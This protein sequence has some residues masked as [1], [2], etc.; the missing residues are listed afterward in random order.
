M[1][2]TCFGGDETSSSMTKLR[3]FF[4][5]YYYFFKINKIGYLGMGRKKLLAS[6]FNSQ[7]FFSLLLL[8][9]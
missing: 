7:L 8:L 1:G 4:F 6:D 5:H 9:I 2:Y 3:I